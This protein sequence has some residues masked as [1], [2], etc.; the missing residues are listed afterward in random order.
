MYKPYRF[1]EAR[2][3]RRAS[4]GARVLCKYLTL[5]ET[6]KE[7]EAINLWPHLDIH[8]RTRN[9]RIDRTYI[10]KRMRHRQTEEFPTPLT[11]CSLEAALPS[12]CRIENVKFGTHPTSI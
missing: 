5:D 3:Q 2:E 12:S 1:H 11:K 6:E 8:G 10:V 7:G 9:G 4:A